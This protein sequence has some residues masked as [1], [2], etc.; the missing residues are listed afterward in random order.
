MRN[1]PAALF[2]SCPSPLRQTHDP[3]RAASGASERAAIADSWEAGRKAN[4]KVQNFRG[5]KSAD[6]RGTGAFMQ[7]GRV[8]LELGGKA[9]GAELCAVEL[10]G[11]PIEHASERM[12]WFWMIRLPR[13]SPTPTLSCWNSRFTKAVVENAAEQTRLRP[14]H[15]TRIAASYVRKSGAL[16]GGRSGD[17]CETWAW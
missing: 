6:G 8:V 11:T 16:S 3:I 17:S 12:G 9:V 13:P 1:H 10:P 5:W 14:I 2:Y 4:F 15:R 7:D